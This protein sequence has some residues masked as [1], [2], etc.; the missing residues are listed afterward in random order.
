MEVLH[1]YYQILGVP[2][3]ATQEQIKKAYRK[4][5]VKF[6]PDKGGPTANEDKLKSVNE[7]YSAIGSPS[8]RKEF[9]R[10]WKAQQ[11]GNGAGPSNPASPPKW[12]KAE[13]EAY[14]KFGGKPKARASSK[15]SAPKPPPKAR[16]RPTGPPPPS[17]YQSQ[18]EPSPRERRE[19]AEREARERQSAEARQKAA[20]EQQ[21]AA[22]R[23]RAAEA[24]ERKE[25]EAV[26]QKRKEAQE[27]AERE[28]RE[29]QAAE[30]KRRERIR[31]RNT[32]LVVLLLFI[33]LIVF[34]ATY[35][36][37]SRPTSGEWAMEP[38]QAEKSHERAT[39]EEPTPP[40]IVITEA[41]GIGPFGSWELIGKINHRFGPAEAVQTEYDE[42][43]RKVVIQHRLI[44][45]ADVTLYFVDSYGAL[46]V[47]AYCTS[48]PLF[49]DENAFHVGQSLSRIRRF[50]NSQTLGGYEVRG[51]KDRHW[52]MVIINDALGFIGP[53]G[54]NKI[55]YIIGN[56]PWDVKELSHELTGDPNYC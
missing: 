15:R 2:E 32:I 33:G 44:S 30:V 48:S 8:K 18:R 45:G 1:D 27:R 55:R 14:V 42:T 21:E 11:S 36:N 51:Y 19:Q 52:E 53:R 35:G 5:S 31:N 34:T 24:R 41:S 49:Q 17:G 26:E 7:A 9:D 29:R 50:Y 4:L 54:S 6:H 39:Y 3:D 10:K 16:T 47:A 40:S 38:T 25:R 12:T 28:A 37:S 13:E 23:I 46:K 22:E 56:G 43:G 20:R